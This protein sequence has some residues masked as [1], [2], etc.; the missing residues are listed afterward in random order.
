MAAQPL[1]KKRLQGYVHQHKVIIIWI[2][3]GI[4]CQMN[5]FKAIEQASD[6]EATTSS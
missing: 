6:R 2:D 1:Q 3:R 4:I 5:N